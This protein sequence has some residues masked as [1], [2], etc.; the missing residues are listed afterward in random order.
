MCSVTFCD[1]GWDALRA[2]L[3]F[4]TVRWRLPE[5]TSSCLCLLAEGSSVQE[6]ISQDF[7]NKGHTGL[8][9]LDT[10]FESLIKE[11]T[12]KSLPFAQ[13]SLLTGLLQ[14]QLKGKKKCTFLYKASSDSQC[15]LE[16]NLA[17]YLFISILSVLLL[18][19]PPH[20]SL[21]NKSITAHSR[22]KELATFQGP[23]RLLR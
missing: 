7:G 22:Q 11:E 17:F 3:A 5:K 1:R 12:M 13:E 4:P 19:P 9:R 6:E 2:K 21:R 18:A 15:K 23:W 8:K 20:K 10:H 14:E 16:H